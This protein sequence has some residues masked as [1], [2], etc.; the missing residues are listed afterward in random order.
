MR[1]Y[2]VYAIEEGTVI[3]HIPKGKALKVIETLR[4]YNEDKILTV[5]ANLDSKKFGKKDLIKIEKRELTED[6]ANKLAL[7]APRA[8]LNIIRDHKIVKKMSVNLPKRLKDISCHNPMCITRKEDIKTK[9]DVIN[10]EPLQLKCFY[11]E[12]VME[13]EDVLRNI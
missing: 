11:C 7:I 6:E 10:R 9:F 4:L 2:R 1:P 13:K 3:D 12:H 8:T 5:G